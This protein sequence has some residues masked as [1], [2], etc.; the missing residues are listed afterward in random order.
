M[1]ASSASNA[2][3]PAPWR[4]R[5]IILR[6]Y[7]SACLE[8]ASA[9]DDPF[10]LKLGQYRAQY[11]GVLTDARA[12]LIAANAATVASLFAIPLGRA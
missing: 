4:E 8:Y 6:G 9:A 1:R 10:T 2:A 11:D 3:F 5:L 12:T 7:I